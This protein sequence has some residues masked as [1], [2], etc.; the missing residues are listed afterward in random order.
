MRCT[1]LTITG[2]LALLL[3]L[4]GCGK[5][6]TWGELTGQQAPPAPA[7]PAQPLPQLAPSTATATPIPVSPDE[8]IARFQSLRP[9]EITDLALQQLTAL[10]Q[11]ADRITEINADGSPVTKNGLNQLERLT[12][13]RQLRLNATQMDDEACQKIAT[14]SSLELL[15]L[16]DTAITDVGVAALSGL[17]NL[18]HLE[19]TR[20]RLSE[21][22]FQAIGQL[23]ALKTSHIDATNLNDRSLAMVCNARTLTSLILSR[24]SITDYGLAA[25][26][27]LEPLE[28]LEIGSTSITGEGLVKVMKG[29]GLKN[30]RYLGVYG[31]PLNER[32]AKAISTMKGLEELNI[33]EVPLM[34]D[35]GLDNLIKGMK[36]L[37]KI[38]LSKCAGIEGSG[39][40]SLKNSKSMEVILIDQCPGVGDPVISILKTIKG[41]K[42]VSLGSTSVSARARA[43]LQSA[44]PDLMIN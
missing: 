42:R 41:L 7:L 14:L 15:T 8:V 31:C 1:N 22:A 44:L 2:C 37:Q 23:P 43:E 36:Q 4:I 13:L 5:I 16:A 25:L 10:S 32:G 3:S 33:G 35:I 9:L 29:G 12:G 20:C 26:A 6:P 19:L 17:S 39:L 21:N 24:N 34:N 38:N 27:K 11:G 40:R 28:Y 30:L 18:K